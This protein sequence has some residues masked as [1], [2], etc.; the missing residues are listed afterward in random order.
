[1]CRSSA[2]H[3]HSTAGSSPG[4][5]NAAENTRDFQIQ[6]STNGTTWTTVATITGNQFNATSHLVATTTARFVRLNITTGARGGQS[7][8]ARIYELEVYGP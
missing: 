3:G 1:M 7:N 5:E 4:G 2:I 6:V 8:T